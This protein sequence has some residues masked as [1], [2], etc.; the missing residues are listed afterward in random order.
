MN[1]FKD[2]CLKPDE[3]VWTPCNLLAENALMREVI[4]I[5]DVT[6]RE[7]TPWF[8]LASD[9]PIGNLLW[10]ERHW[11]QANNCRVYIEERQ[12]QIAALL[13]ERG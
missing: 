9:Q 10:T 1:P 4:K 7:I 5:Q 12:R 6:I 3:L 8:G 2:A 11:T 13:K